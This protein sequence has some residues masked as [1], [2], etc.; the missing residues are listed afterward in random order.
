[1]TRILFGAPNKD[2]KETWQPSQSIDWDTVP[3]ASLRM[4]F[5]DF[6]EMTQDISGDELKTIDA[7]L[8]EHGAYTLTQARDKG[9]R[10]VMQLLT[11]TRIKR[12]ADAYLLKG[13]IDSMDPRF[14]QSQIARMDE[15]LATFEEK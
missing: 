1:M 3:M 12:E 6:I 9:Y 4:G 10:R 7:F 11:F 13:M 8:E 14:P 15:L 5:N 2:S